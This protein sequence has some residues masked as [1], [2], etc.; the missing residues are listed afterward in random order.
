MQK[1]A[2]VDS[3]PPKHGCLG[4]WMHQK[5]FFTMHACLWHAIPSKP[6]PPGCAS[7]DPEPSVG[8]SPAV[9]CSVALP[10]MG[11]TTRPRNAWPRPVMVLTSSME[12]VK[13]LLHRRKKRVG[14]CGKAALGGSLPSTARVRSESR[15]P[16]R[17]VTPPTGRSR[18]MPLPGDSC[19]AMPRS[20]LCRRTTSNL[21]PQQPTQRVL[22]W[23]LPPSVHVDGDRSQATNGPMLPSMSVWAC[24]WGFFWG[25]GGCFAHSEAIATHTVMPVSIRSAPDSDS[26][27][28]SSAPA[29]GANR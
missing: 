16:S 20:C 18:G 8:S 21:A 23:G 22:R 4:T 6:P 29:S 28:C 25:G 1:L 15:W 24:V 14:C 19:A 7:S 17:Q 26:T 5:T 12:D 10:A 11:S 9:R 27:G 13:N 2:V 3:Q